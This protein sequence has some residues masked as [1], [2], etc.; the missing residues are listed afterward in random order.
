[1]IALFNH[2]EVYLKQLILLNHCSGTAGEH[3]NFHVSA[4]RYLI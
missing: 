4:S 3:M 1:M 2:T